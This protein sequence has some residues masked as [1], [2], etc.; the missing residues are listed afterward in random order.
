[1]AKPG[2]G[3]ARNRH[4]N[5]LDHE[6]RLRKR[7]EENKGNIQMARPKNITVK[8][9]TVTCV[10]CGATKTGPSS[11]IRRS[12]LCGSAACRSELYRQLWEKRNLVRRMKNLLVCQHCGRTFTHHDLMT[13]GCGRKCSAIIANQTRKEKQHACQ[14]QVS[15]TFELKSLDIPDPF[16]TI[17]D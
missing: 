4:L 10:I 12:T 11:H 15:Y 1:M 14:D 8:L 13:K 17:Y 7:A 9:I 5:D 2:Y 3:S 16:E 6:L